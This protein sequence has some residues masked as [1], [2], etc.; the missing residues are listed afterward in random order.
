[1]NV[2]FDGDNLLICVNQ[3][4]TQLDV[5]KDLY[6]AWKAWAIQGDN[7]KYLPALR[8]VGGDPISDVKNLGATF[9]LINGWR[10]RPQEADHWLRVDGNLFTDPSGSSPFVPTLGD[11]NVTIEST[12]SNLSDSTLAQL[13]EI[14]YASFQEA[15]N[16]DEFNVTGRAVSGINYPAGTLDSPSDNLA[17]AFTI[18]SMRGFGSIRVFGELSVDSGMSWDVRGLIFIGNH[19]KLTTVHIDDSSLTHNCIFRGLTVDGTLDGNNVLEDCTVGD[20]LHVEG[21]CARCELSGKI[22]LG[23][24]TGVHIRDC[25]SGALSLDFIAEIDMGGSGR[26]L[27]VHRWSGHLKISNLTGDSVAVISC[28]A[29]GQVIVGDTCTAGIIIVAGVGVKVVDERPAESTCQI[30][31]HYNVTPANVAALVA[32]GSLTQEEHNQLFSIPDETLTPDEHT[33]LYSIPLTGGGSGGASAD[34]IADAVLK[35]L[36]PFL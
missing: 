29:G 36:M 20:L 12:V 7:S 9:F 21:E 2:T 11:Y 13:P 33:R 17:D 28:N 18:R 23:G 19:A 24:S 31:S 27:A 1:M 22:T 5:K 34:E 3:G 16:I 14:E 4:V 26:N 30:L 10:I 32:A 6:S 8:T 25:Y 15:V 35:K